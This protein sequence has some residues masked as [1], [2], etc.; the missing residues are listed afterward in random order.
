MEEHFQKLRAIYKK[1]CNLMVTEMEKHFSSKVTYIV[2]EGG[3]FV[4]CTLPDGCD[5][6][7][8]CTKAIQ[9]YKVAVVPG[10]A[11]MVHDTDPTTSFRMNFSTPTDEQIVE[12]CQKLGRLSKELF[13][14]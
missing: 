10:N 14:E 6:N 11:F 9:E 4:W 12:G 8:F 13:G 2:P 5:M 3:L 1:K 7:A